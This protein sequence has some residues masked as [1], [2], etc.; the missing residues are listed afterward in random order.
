MDEV[1]A[2][3]AVLSAGEDYDF[4]LLRRADDPRDPWAGHWA[5]PGGHRDPMD[6]SLLATSVRE[7]D[8]ECGVSLYGIEPTAV[9]PVSLAGRAVG[10]SVLVAAY[11]WHLPHKPGLALDGTEMVSAAWMS[12]GDFCNSDL[13]QQAVLSP[14]YPLEPFPYFL[15]HDHPLWGFT[16]NILRALLI[17]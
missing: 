1:R 9:L 7:C 6:D 5:F 11:Y 8:E 14:E 16:Y 15:L 3:V 12:R 10:K 2:A 13:H 4:L 17:D